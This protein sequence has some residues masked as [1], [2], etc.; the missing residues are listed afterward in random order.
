MDTSHNTVPGAQPVD[1]AAFAAELHILRIAHWYPL[2]REFATKI[3]YVVA[4]VREFLGERGKSVPLP[5]PHRQDGLPRP[6]KKLSALEC[7]SREL[8]AMR[9]ECRFTAVPS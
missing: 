4:T 7:Q 6:S 9:H 5:T 2:P 3:L 8:L 1:L